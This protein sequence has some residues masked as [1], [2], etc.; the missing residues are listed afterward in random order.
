MFHQE[1]ASSV[2]NVST[3]SVNPSSEDKSLEDK[4]AQ[5]VEIIHSGK[6][7]EEKSEAIWGILQNV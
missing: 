6:S 1:N 5:I 7:Q 2:E 4:A 3:A